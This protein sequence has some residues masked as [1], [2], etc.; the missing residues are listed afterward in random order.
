MGRKSVWRKNDKYEV[1][2]ADAQTQVTIHAFNFPAVNEKSIFFPITQK[3]NQQTL[4]SLNIMLLSYFER[5][6]YLINW[7]GY[8]FIFAHFF[9]VFNDF[10]ILAHNVDSTFSSL[11]KAFSHLSNKSYQLKKV[12]PLNLAS[13][14]VDHIGLHERG[15]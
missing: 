2:V 4:F 10:G 7:I 14:T 8:R 13:Q 9:S 15:D 1:W 5:R 12:S 3:Y 6:W 11:I